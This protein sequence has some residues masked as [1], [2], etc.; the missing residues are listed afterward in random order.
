MSVPREAI[1]PDCLSH[2]PRHSIYGLFSYIW[3]VYAW[4][5]FNALN[6]WE[7]VLSSLHV[8]TVRCTSQTLHPYTSWVFWV[9]W[10]E[11]R[12][13][14]KTGGPY[15]VRVNQQQVIIG[16]WLFLILIPL[17]LMTVY[18][19]NSIYIYIYI[20]TY[21]IQTTLDFW[22]S[23]HR[24][25]LLFGQL[26]PA[27]LGRFGMRVKKQRRDAVTFGALKSRSQ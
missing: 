10:N 13:P 12:P 26:F 23:E 5:I 21:I 20:D 14:K 3:L 4:Y 2:I 7:N 11:N 8:E 6:I 25:I 24:F 27:R 18:T 1:A 9:D 17:L 22:P 19:Y 15:A 16:I